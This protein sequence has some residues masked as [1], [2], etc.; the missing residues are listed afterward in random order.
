MSGFLFGLGLRLE[1][2]LEA[3]GKRLHGVS[4]GGTPFGHYTAKARVQH[5]H[6]EVSGSRPL[7]PK[8]NSDKLILRIQLLEFRG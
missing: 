8:N 3:E 1:L 5:S 7:Y 6:A 4:Q 2:S